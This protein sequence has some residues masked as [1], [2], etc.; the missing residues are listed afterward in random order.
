MS[1]CH[2]QVL[3]LVNC[4]IKS[5]VANL[6]VVGGLMS[7]SMTSG[8]PQGSVPGLVFNVTKTVGLSALSA[9]LQI[10]TKQ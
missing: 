4:Y 7:R 9:S 5:G 2:L 1:K 6:M 3:L 8:V 10:D